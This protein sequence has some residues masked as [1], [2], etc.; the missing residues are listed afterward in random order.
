MCSVVGAV[1]SPASQVS[2]QGRIGT[3]SEPCQTCTQ[4]V[5]EDGGSTVHCTIQYNTVQY[6]TRHREWWEGGIVVV[7]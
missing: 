4:G 3:L 5:G 2:H 7:T 6:S 1:F